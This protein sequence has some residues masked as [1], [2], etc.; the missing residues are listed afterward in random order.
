MARNNSSPKKAPKKK[1]ASHKTAA[2]HK[3][4]MNDENRPSNIVQKAS[5]KKR[6]SIVIPNW[7]SIVTL[8][9]NSRLVEK[10]HRTE[11]DFSHL[12]DV[13]NQLKNDNENSDFFLVGTSPF[14]YDEPNSCPT[15]SILITSRGETPPEY[16]RDT[17]K[18]TIVSFDDCGITWKPFPKGQN[19]IYALKQ[20]P[21][22]ILLEDLVNVRLWNLMGDD[23]N[24]NADGKLDIKAVR[25][26]YQNLDGEWIEDTYHEDCG[27]ITD[28]CTDI[29][30]G[31]GMVLKDDQGEPIL[32]KEGD[33]IAD[34]NSLQQ[35]KE[36]INTAFETTH[37]EREKH[38]AMLTEKHPSFASIQTV[39]VFPKN[40]DVLDGKGFRLPGKIGLVNVSYGY[41][42]QIFPEELNHR[43]V[44]IP[45]FKFDSVEA[46]LASQEE[47]TTAGRN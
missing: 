33:I 30:E 35:L 29:C 8:N 37:T 25:F 24:R 38:I 47:A 18:K 23:L 19:R 36:A 40:R 15:I 1:A 32:D 16:V 34:P 42:G 2:K 4:I 41:A 21:G 7:R 14:V 28:V 45:V 6:P 43:V 46:F 11:W 9:E 39:Q 31:W 3:I 12:P 20:V 44:D 26:K 13:L 27:E 22:E 17:V 5:N 10:L